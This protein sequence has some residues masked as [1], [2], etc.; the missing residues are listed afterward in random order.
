MLDKSMSH[1][2][3]LETHPV[4]DLIVGKCYVILV[5]SVPGHTI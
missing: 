3:Q 2:M 5:G 4:V 1:L